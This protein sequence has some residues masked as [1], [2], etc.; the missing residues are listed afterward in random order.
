MKIEH[1]AI[2]TVDL[3]R[4]KSFYI[5]YF[6]A[7]AG[8]KYK[9]PATGFESYFLA[10]SSGSRL[11][12]MSKPDLAAGASAAGKHAGL[13]HFAVSAGGREDV[14]RLTDILRDDG[15]TVASAPRVTG[16]GYFES[17]VLDPDGNLIEITIGKLDRLT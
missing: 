8:G 6:G 15:F 2:W 12:L 4:L 1:L 5:K 11:E 7:K 9:N 16:D 17:Q 13:A 14:V 10:F 3:E